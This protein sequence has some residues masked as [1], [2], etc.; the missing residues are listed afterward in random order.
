MRL[1]SSSIPVPCFN[2]L[3]SLAYLINHRY[4]DPTCRVLL[5]GRL[6]LAPCIFASNLSVSHDAALLLHQWELSGNP[7]HRRHADSDCVLPLVSISWASSY[8]SACAPVFQWS[9]VCSRKYRDSFQT[10]C[11]DLLLL[12]EVATRLR[13]ALNDAAALVQQRLIYFPEPVSLPASHSA[14]AP[15]RFLLMC[16]TWQ[17]VT[18]LLK[19]CAIIDYGP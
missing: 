4:A 10:G 6:V 15:P 9:C 1:H 7:I 3:N 2:E 8:V 18:N 12:R 17:S 16:V 19:T 14:T 5:I 13:F 11:W